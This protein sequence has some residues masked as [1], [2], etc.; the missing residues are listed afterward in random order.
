RPPRPSTPSPTARRAISDTWS[1]LFRLQRDWPVE[2]EL[3]ERFCGDADVAPFREHL[4]ARAARRAD[5]DTDCGALGA[6][7]DRTDEGAERGA[8]ADRLGR[9]LVAADS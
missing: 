3:Q 8:A 5:Q 9:P 4:S 7:D 6:T 1:L 2:P